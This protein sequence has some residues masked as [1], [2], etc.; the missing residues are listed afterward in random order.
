MLARSAETLVGSGFRLH[1]RDPATGLDCIGVLAAALQRIGRPAPLPTGY[2][3]RTRFVPD[4]DSIAAVAGL[5]AVG[6]SARPGDVLFVRCAPD[7]FHLMIATTTGRYVHAHAGLKRVVLSRDP[8]AW[9]IVRQWRL[10]E[11]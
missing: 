7:Q 4:L 3:L 2:R 8:L 6:A 1:G 10:I 11:T 9:P 5:T